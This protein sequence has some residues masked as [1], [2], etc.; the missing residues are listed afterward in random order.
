MQLENKVIISIGNN[1]ISI[2]NNIL[3]LNISFN[4]KLEENEFLQF[5]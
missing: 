4:N 1:Y 5:M 2:E 3:I